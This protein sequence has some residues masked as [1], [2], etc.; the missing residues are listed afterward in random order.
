MLLFIIVI[1]AI[2]V[3]III[4]TEESNPQSW[5]QFVHTEMKTDRKGR[6]GERDGKRK[7]LIIF[8]LRT[9]W[10]VSSSRPY[11]EGFCHGNYTF[12]H[13]SLRSRAGHINKSK[14]ES[15]QT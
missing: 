1:I 14:T 6:A 7:I 11:V 4:V 5:L 10:K 8:S 13:F 15:G 12:W 3:I 9:I 2:V